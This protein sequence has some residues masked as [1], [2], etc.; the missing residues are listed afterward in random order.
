MLASCSDAVHFAEFGYA[1]CE[2]MPPNAY[3]VGCEL[4]GVGVREHGYA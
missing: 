2:D 4:L 3:L 1:G